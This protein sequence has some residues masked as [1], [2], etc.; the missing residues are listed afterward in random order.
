M[1]TFVWKS[2]TGLT[3]LCDR[4]L[5]NNCLGAQDYPERN[6][7]KLSEVVNMSFL[8]IEVVVKWMHMLVRIHQT[9]IKSVHFLICKLYFSYRL[10]TKVKVEARKL[11]CTKYN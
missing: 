2:R 9:M 11:H 4:N 1:I 5:G 10:Q 7:R 8:V 6:M 3:T